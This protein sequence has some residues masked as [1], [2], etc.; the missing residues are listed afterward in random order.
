[1][2]QKRPILVSRSNVIFH[3]D[4]ARFQLLFQ[5]DKPHVARNVQNKLREFGWKLLLHPP[6][7]PNIALSDF[8]LFRSLQH[9]LA[10]KKFNNMNK[11]KSALKK[12]FDNKPKKFYT[13]GIM[14][15]PKKWE[16]IVEKEGDYIFS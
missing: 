11:I 15:L 1:M 6:Y 8:Y 16:E 12:Y 14:S 2:A 5:H 7:S 3:H 9:F 10:G 13:N 4:N